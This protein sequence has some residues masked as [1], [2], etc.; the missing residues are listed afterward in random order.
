MDEKKAKEILK[1]EGFKEIYLH[2][3][4]PNEHYPPHKHAK[5]A[6]HIILKGT[7]EI[8]TKGISKYLKTGDRFD[9]KP[10]EVHEAF[11]GNEGCTYIVA[12][13]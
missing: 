8:K 12:N 3:D 10:L 11:I 1:K 2:T 5:Y 4:S 13:K 6:A 9:V 7:M